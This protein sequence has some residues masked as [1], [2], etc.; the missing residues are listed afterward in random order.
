M[1]ARRPGGGAVAFEL[2]GDRNG[3]PLLF[4]HGLA[5]SRRSAREL[6]PAA[7]ELGYL[8][9]APD[10]P[11]I[12]LSDPRRLERVADWV[13]DA[14][15]VLDSLRFPHTALLGVSGGGPF[16]AACAAKLPDRAVALVL[17]SSLGMSTWPT[18]GM[19]AGDRFSLAVAKRAPAFG[20]W[21]LGRLAALAGSSPGMFLELA[22]TGLPEIDRQTLRRPQNRSAF[23]ESFRESFRRGRAGVA[24]DLRVLTRDWGFDLGTIH[25]PT[26]VHHGSVDTTVPVDHARRFVEA[27]PTA[28]LRLHPDDGHFSLLPG[29]AKSMLMEL[30]DVALG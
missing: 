6:A 26:W 16:A 20:G 1:H 27:I 12:G 25:V 24:Q 19:A 4:C 14:A 8:V 17:V 21:F 10:R 13:E 29:A 28:Q 2:A 9:I 18:H 11:G 3:R 15:V 30:R 23:I 5:D 22:M 7:Q